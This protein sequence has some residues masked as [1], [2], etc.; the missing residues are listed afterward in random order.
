MKQTNE[1]VLTDE[2]AIALREQYREFSQKFSH[3]R[4]VR[5]SEPLTSFID[6]MRL[7]KLSGV[8][9]SSEDQWDLMADYVDRF[10][11]MRK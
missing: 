4:K 1:Y 2:A 3:A 7:L 8:V 5:D 9:I 11:G 10:W 6:S